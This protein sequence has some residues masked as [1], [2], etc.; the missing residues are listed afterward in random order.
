MSWTKGESPA[1][2]G[3]IRASLTT[4]AVPALRRDSI[5]DLVL[6]NIA[7]WWAY[8]GSPRLR[9]QSGSLT[10]WLLASSRSLGF[11][12]AALSTRFPVR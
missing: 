5:A 6:F 2:F 7:L 12:V 10:L 1:T 4:P 11:S 3:P 9:T 8:G